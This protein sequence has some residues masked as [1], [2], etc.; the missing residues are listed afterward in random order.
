MRMMVR[1]T[2]AYMGAYMTA[3]RRLGRSRDDQRFIMRLQHC[4]READKQLQGDSFQIQY[5][6]YLGVVIPNCR[7]Q[8]D[9]SEMN[10]NSL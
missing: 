5:Y 4:L 6:L 2:V 10:E 3:C 8:G 1:C 7:Q 9:H